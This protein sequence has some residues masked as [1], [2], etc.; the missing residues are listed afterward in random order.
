MGNKSLSFKNS[1]SEK[2][3]KYFLGKTYPP[4]ICFHSPEKPNR[5]KYLD[6]V[7]PYL[8]LNLTMLDWLPADVIENVK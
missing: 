3:D 1:L 6:I 4:Y 7:N 2:G 5:Q 8:S